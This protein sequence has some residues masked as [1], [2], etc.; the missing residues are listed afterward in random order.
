MSD[1]TEQETPAQRE[2]RLIR[3][4]LAAMSL[5]ALVQNAIQE[6]RAEEENPNYTAQPH[7]IYELQSR[8]TTETLAYMIA[9]LS[10]PLVEER[11]VAAW[12]LGQMQSGAREYHAF[13]VEAVDALVQGLDRWHDDPQTLESIGVALG[14]RNDPRAIPALVAL[15]AYPDARA[16]FGVAFGLATSE[17]PLAVTTLLELTSDPAE[18]VRDWA[19]FA[20]TYLCADGVEIRAALLARTSDADIDIR[21]QAVEALAVRHDSHTLS[22][23][24]AAIADGANGTPILDAALS[25]ADPQ[26]HPALVALRG[27]V[28]SWD[29]DT[30]EE[31]IAACAPKT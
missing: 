20:F 17:E 13:Q 31:A 2:L 28:N 6:L 29:N 11:E 24:L 23:L 30:L 14:H 7:A 10:S 12:V 4:Q 3:Q 1:E 26:L 21:S 5:A 27:K 22:A 25:L 8:S 9:L 15:K 16:R 19:T 18:R